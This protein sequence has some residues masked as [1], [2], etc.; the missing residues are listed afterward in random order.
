MSLTRASSFQ[1]YKY[2]QTSWSV[3]LFLLA[4]IVDIVPGRTA[5]KNQ[6][7]ERVFSAEP[8]LGYYGDLIDVSFESK[9]PIAS[10]FIQLNKTDRIL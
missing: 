7:E 5:F 1:V 3:I 2:H 10:Q 8:M 6:K 9:N 4:T